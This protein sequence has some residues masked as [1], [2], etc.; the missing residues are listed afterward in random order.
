MKKIITIILC[1]LINFVSVQAFASSKVNKELCQNQVR[2]FD[3]NDITKVM[4]AIANTLQDSDFIVEEL[5]PDLG[6]MRAKK[7]FKKRYLNKARFAGQSVL[8]AAATSY[9]VFT[10]G[11]TAGYTYAPARKLTDEFH[12]KNA[13]A[14]VNVNFEKFGKDKVR[15]R[16][17]A[18][19]K[20][21][22]NA[23]GYSYSTNAPLR[24]FRIY[25]KNVYDEFFNQL[26]EKLN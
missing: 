20:I 5:E 17:T 1:I 19:L 10:W 13:I 8:L 15:V 16:M 22:Q 23:E 6:Y 11:S 3:T 9:A 4:V 12:R 7:V 21:R 24:S 26:G 18:V 2:I 25:D 14:D